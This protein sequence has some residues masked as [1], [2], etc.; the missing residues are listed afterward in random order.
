MV[1]VYHATKV[2]PLERRA[3]G[4]VGSGLDDKISKGDWV[5]FGLISE[6]GFF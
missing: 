4:M 2:K 1:S 6:S 3:K 5:K